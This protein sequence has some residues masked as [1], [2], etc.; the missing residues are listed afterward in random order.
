MDSDGEPVFNLYKRER[1]GNYK[2]QDVQE[3]LAS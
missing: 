3:L 1:P 2:C